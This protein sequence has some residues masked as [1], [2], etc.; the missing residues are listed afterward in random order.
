MGITFRQGLCP[1]S[2]VNGLMGDAGGI[3]PVDVE[4]QRGVERQ[5]RQFAAGTQV[6][7]T[8]LNGGAEMRE[9]GHMISFHDRPFRHGQ[10][11]HAAVQHN[12]CFGLADLRALHGG[13]TDP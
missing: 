3:G 8:F 7:R 4:V 11:R 6:G 10:S 5:V 9:D 12:G 2:A 13:M 1:G